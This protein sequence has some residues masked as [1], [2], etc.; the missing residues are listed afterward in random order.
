MMGT[1]DRLSAREQEIVTYVARG[2]SNR[3]IGEAL[4][5]SENTV[6]NHLR[7]IL[8]KLELKNR[9]QVATYAL[10]HGIVKSHS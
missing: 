3:G 6:R 9:V 1:F 4:G 8:D 2:L 5:L 7:S 10:E